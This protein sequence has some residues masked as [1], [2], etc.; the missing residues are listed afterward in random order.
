MT[1]YPYSHFLLNGRQIAFDDV[2]SLAVPHYTDF[3]FATLAFLKEWLDGSKTFVQKT[4]GSTGTPKEIVITRDQMIASAE[5]TQNALALRPGFK[6][7]VCLDTRFIAGKMM[8]VRSL[9]TGME[10]TFQEPVANPLTALS[11]TSAVDFVAFV[12]Y[13]IEE[14]L[15]SPQSNFLNKLGTVIIGGAPMKS[16]TV[17]RL[18]SFSSRFFITYGMTET[19]SHIALQRISPTQQEEV[20]Q[21]LSGVTVESDGRG[22]LV[23]SVPWLTEKVVTNDIVEIISSK[24]FRWIGRLDNI[25]N[26]GGFKANPEKI[27]FQ[28][29]KIFKS[30]N[31]DRRF[32]I[33]GIPD[34]RTGQ[35]VSL[36]VEGFELPGFLEEIQ[37]R[38]HLAVQRFEIPRSIYF[39]DNFQYT[40]SKKL[41]RQATLRRIGSR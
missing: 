39:V 5:A 11:E 30:L 17:Q 14:V 26:T 21:C 27:E 9:V 19:M 41:D 22:C 20:F 31:V 40:S 16:D 10:M 6:A 37:N 24:N 23:A 8:C 33:A 18:K 2:R 1:R 12:P 36:F 34:D 29:E 32:F 38:L 15:A 35:R 28:I 3:E 13:Q 25:I 7:F 4:S